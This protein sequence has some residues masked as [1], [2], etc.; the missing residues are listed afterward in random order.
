MRGIE[1]H[2]ERES[3]REREKRRGEKLNSSKLITGC[4]TVV[5]VRERVKGSQIESEREREREREGEEGGVEPD[6]V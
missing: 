1:A 5:C 4:S 3:E 2:I 6:A